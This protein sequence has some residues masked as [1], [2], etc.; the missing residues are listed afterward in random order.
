VERQVSLVSEEGAVHM[1][2]PNVPRT[3]TLRLGILSV[4]RAP[5][6]APM[7]E[8]TEYSTLYPSCLVTV[9]TPRV[10]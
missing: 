2:S 9:F 8:S 6:R 7:A 10:A 1:N 5:V 3:S 4:R